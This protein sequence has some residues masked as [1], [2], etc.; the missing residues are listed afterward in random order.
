MT[1]IPGGDT[2]PSPPTDRIQAFIS[3]SLEIDSVKQTQAQF[4]NAMLERTLE[5]ARLSVKKGSSPIGCVI[6]DSKRNI[7]SEG[8]NR[9]SEPWPRKALEIGNSGLA[10]A[11]MV[12]FYRAGRSGLEHPEDLTLYTSL[13]PCLMCGGAM[14]MLGLKRVVWACDDAWGGSGRLIAWNQH[15]AFSKTRV[16]AHPNPELELEAA[17]LFAPEAKRVYPGKGWRLW[18]ERYPQVCADIP[19]DLGTKPKLRAH[20][21]R[22]ANDQISAKAKP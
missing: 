8:R 21:R 1:L 9:S 14:G 10:H 12:A 15:P 20:Q 3:D 19:E 5:L 11:E 18:K 6:V 7:V 16:E 4:D 13:E 17:R 2:P 22:V